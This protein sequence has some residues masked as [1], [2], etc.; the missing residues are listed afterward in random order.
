MDARSS[1]D[2][3]CG[4][5]LL[6]WG[7]D[8]ARLELDAPSRIDPSA[9]TMTTTTSTTTTST[10]L[11]SP[12]GMTIDNGKI[13]RTLQPVLLGQRQTERSTDRETESDMTRRCSAEICRF[14]P[15][16][17]YRQ[18]CETVAALGPGRKSSPPDDK[19]ER[20]AI[21]TDFFQ[22]GKEGGNARAVLRRFDRD[23]M[24]EMR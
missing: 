2:Q 11:L 21:A 10:L 17:F 16:F 15:P 12:S 13:Y 4:P 7:W 14:A 18:A 6:C 19:G 20:E 5:A 9:M 1:T 3:R 23:L 24:H 8:D 22:F